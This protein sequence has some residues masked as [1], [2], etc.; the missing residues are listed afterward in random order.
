MSH[1]IAYCEEHWPDKGLTISAQQY[2]ESFYQALGFVTA[3][4]PYLEDG[5]AHIKMIR[6]SIPQ[7]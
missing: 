3:S 4:S 5:I 7:S 1:A 6:E 2:L